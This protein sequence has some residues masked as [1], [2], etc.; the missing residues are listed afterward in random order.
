M[1]TFELSC[2]ECGNTSKVPDNLAGKKIKCK[3]CQKIIVAT[4][5]AGPGGKST[6]TAIKS[7]TKA[8]S[9]K[10][11][12][13]DRNPY[14]MREENLAA[15]CPFCAQLMDPPDA[16][17]CLHCGYDMQKRHRKESRITEEI[18]AAD[19]LIWHLPTVGCFFGIMA[20]IG[21]CVFC[22]VQMGDWVSGSFADGLVKPGCFTTWIVIMCL[23]PI[24]AMSKLIFKRLVWNFTPPEKEVKLK[25]EF[26]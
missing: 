23:I 6:A 4:A 19:Y 12:E 5:P 3:K 11:E 14:V 20:L 22:G 25:G 9:A 8:G 16:K 10:K 2:P 15:R 17:I 26:E 7:G 24:W 18:T 21:I 1:A 13:D